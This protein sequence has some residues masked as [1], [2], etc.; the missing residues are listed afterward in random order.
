MHQISNIQK[1]CNFQSV[2]DIA[3]KNISREIENYDIKFACLEGKSDDIKKDC[4]RSGYFEMSDK[5]DSIEEAIKNIKIGHCLLIDGGNYMVGTVRHKITECSGIVYNLCSGRK[6]MDDNPIMAYDLDN[7]RT[8]KDLL[9]LYE[10]LSDSMPEVKEI[11][12]NKEMSEFDPF[13][14]TRPQIIEMWNAVHDALK[15]IPEEN[16]IIKGISYTDFII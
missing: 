7:I 16:K 13:S 3:K 11:L 5:F 1:I 2:L 14:D 6:V 8:P 10:K 4:I 15:E 12:E 9:C